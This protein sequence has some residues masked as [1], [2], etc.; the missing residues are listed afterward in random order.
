MIFEPISAWAAHF[1]KKNACSLSIMCCAFLQMRPKTKK[2]QIHLGKFMSENYAPPSFR[3]MVSFS[4]A[5][6]ILFIPILRQGSKEI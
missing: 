5:I 1:N 3:I 6:L 2:A 4:R